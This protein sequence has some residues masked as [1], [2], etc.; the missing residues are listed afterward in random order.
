MAGYVQSPAMLLGLWALGGV[1]SLFG[2]IAYAEL[3]AAMPRAGGQYV[4]LGRAFG[5]LWGFLYGWTFLFAINTGFIAAVSVAFAKYVGVFLPAIGEGTILF[6]LG[7]PFTTAQAV[8]LVVVLV[9]TWVN[10]TRPAHGRAGAERVHRRQG[11]GDRRALRARLALGRGSAA[12]FSSPGGACALGPEGVELGLFAA[13]AVAM[14]KA[15]FAYDAWNSATF[16]AEEVK[17]PERNLVR[18]LLLG[19]ARASPS[20]TAPRSRCTSTWCPLDEMARCRDNRIGGRGRAAA[21]SGSL[22]ERFIAVA[23]LVSAFGC[24]NGLVLSGRPRG[25]RHGARRP[26]LPVGRGH[27]PDLPH[28]ARARSSSRGRWR[29]CSP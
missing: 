24:V 16:A 3:A 17:E 10:V 29:R 12:N 21:C 2:A 25:L 18:S 7:R 26:L 5:P 4:F 14:S 28:A 27:P 20:S 1:L 22:G 8:A 23:I 11:G 19:H 9:L 6:S 13:V 15:L